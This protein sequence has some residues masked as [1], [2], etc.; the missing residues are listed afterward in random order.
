MIVSSLYSLIYAFEER[1]S[2]EN[3][4]E[5]QNGSD[6]EE[7]DPMEGFNQ[8]LED[9][10]KTYG[11]A[12][13]LMEEQISNLEKQEQEEPGGD[14]DVAGPGSASGRP[15]WVHFMLVAYLLTS[16]CA[17]CDLV[18]RQC[19]ASVE[20]KIQFPQCQPWQNNFWGMY[21]VHFVQLF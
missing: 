19:S 15:V 4:V 14:Q 5:H 8:Q 3:T 11:I 21:N 17:P 2:M 20:K 16:P 7:G 13:A 10:V 6:N 12:A 9:I 1:P 18:L